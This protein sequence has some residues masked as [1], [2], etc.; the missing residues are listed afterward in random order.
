MAKLNYLVPLSLV[1]MRIRI[2]CDWNR[3]KN[4]IK[5]TFKRSKETNG[6]KSNLTSTNMCKLR[7]VQLQVIVNMII[8]SIN[9]GLLTY[10]KRTRIQGEEP[11]L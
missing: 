3:S 2:H 8:Y 11:N 4:G 10:Q 7:N 9:E 5:M 1:V 6:I